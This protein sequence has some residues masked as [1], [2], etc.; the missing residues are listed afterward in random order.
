MAKLLIRGAVYASRVPMYRDYRDEMIELVEY[1]GV[2]A[3]TLLLCLANWMSQDDIRKCLQAN[4]I[5]LL[6]DMHQEDEEEDCVL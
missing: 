6:R 4:D 1:G 3:N 2:D 5:T